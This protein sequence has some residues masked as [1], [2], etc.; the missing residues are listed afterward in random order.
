[1]SAV[2]VKTAALKEAQENVRAAEA[3]TSGARA[4]LASARAR[5][6]RERDEFGVAAVKRLEAARE[7]TGVLAEQVVVKVATLEMQLEA[8]HRKEEIAKQLDNQIAVRSA[9]AAIKQLS[10]RLATAVAKKA[11]VDAL[12]I[13]AADAVE[14]GIR[15]QMRNEAVAASTMA[16]VAEAMAARAEAE[17]KAAVAQHA[18][19]VKDATAKGYASSDAKRQVDLAKHLERAAIAKAARKR[20]QARDARSEA[21]AAE[22]LACGKIEERVQSLAV[23]RR[24]E[25]R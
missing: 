1:M 13:A 17:A 5:L 23:E 6:D 18:N 14:A 11:E 19:V 4:A 2:V 20:D 8:A 16:S 7:M 3:R 9:K 12:V 22:K 24:K 15:K 25:Q 21:E 10:T